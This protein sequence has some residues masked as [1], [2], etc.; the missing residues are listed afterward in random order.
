M[1]EHRATGRKGD[2]VESDVRAWVRAGGLAVLMGFAAGLLLNFWVG[3]SNELT[4]PDW[5]RLGGWVCLACVLAMSLVI[6]CALVGRGA[7]G[8]L[9]SLGGPREGS[10]HHPWL[11]VLAVVVAGAVYAGYG[12]LFPDVVYGGSFQRALRWLPAVAAWVAVVQLGRRANVQGRRVVT[13][14]AMGGFAVMA[15]LM[16][17]VAVLVAWTATERKIKLGAELFELA[18]SQQLLNE[19]RVLLIALDGASWDFVEAM[20]HRKE[21]PTLSKI[22]GTG[23]AGPL[24]SLKP[25]ESPRLWTTVV[26]GASAQ[27]HGVASFFSYVV[28]GIRKPLIVNLN[29]TGFPRVRELAVRTG[30]V[31]RA[32]VSSLNN[33]LP[34][35][36]DIIGAVGGRAA[37]IGWWAT[38][39][40]FAVNGIVVSDTFYYHYRAGTRHPGGGTLVDPYGSV[41]P[42]SRLAEFEP[43]R[44]APQDVTDEE[45][46]RFLDVDDEQIEAMRRLRWGPTLEDQ[47]LFLYSLDRTHANVADHL[48]R[49]EPD[50]NLLAVYLR[51]IDIISHVALKFGT[52]LESS[53]GSRDPSDVVRAYY[54]YTDSLIAELIAVAP[55][56]TTVIVVS[57]HGFEKAPSGEYWH[58]QAPAG[59]LFAAGAPIRAGGHVDDIDLFDLFPTL[60]Y[61]FGL[62]VPEDRP[63]GA[64]LDLFDPSFVNDNP[65]RWI[66]S[67]GRFRRLAV[68][69]QAEIG[70]ESR[71]EMIERLRSLG[72]IR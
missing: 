22:A 56:D 48:L 43:L 18:Q 44:V 16:F 52:P 26:T 63:G 47:F 72:Y 41:Y 71:Q 7:Y 33:R 31:Q 65:L 50:L 4:L 11:D 53:R 34:P 1:S 23:V 8:F 24:Q 51:G 37:S 67:Y 3:L 29:G 39:P 58:E 32:V 6:I 42:A 17:V 27:H 45:I 30:L 19:Q 35:L 46:R 55:P 20:M 10:A 61:L 57:D 38:W 66:E 5:F 54:E 2:Y 70:D 69:G 36:R 25:T 62:G 21:L 15:S 64:R 40:A 12:Q 68:R 9:L 14:P 49:T 13:W 60:L 28:P 59:V